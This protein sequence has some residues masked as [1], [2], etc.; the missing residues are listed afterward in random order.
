[1]G[2]NTVAF[3][4]ND[5]MHELRKSPKAVTWGLTYPP[6]SDGWSLNWFDQMN[7]VALENNE[8]LIHSQALKVLP[9][10]HADNTTYLRAG[11]NGI[12]ELRTLRYGKT[13]EG[14]NTVTLELPDWWDKKRHQ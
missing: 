5:F 2:F 1:M 14:K 3:L 12:T 10:F 11:G 7:Q 4:L 6:M 13:K 8:P 9:T